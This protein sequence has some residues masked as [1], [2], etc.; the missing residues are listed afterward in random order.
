LHLEG[1]DD[2]N[3][4][5]EVST[6]LNQWTALKTNNAS[7]GSFDFLDNTAVGQPQRFYRARLIP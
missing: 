4:A 6:N 1:Q 2:R 7:D 5:I 3:Y